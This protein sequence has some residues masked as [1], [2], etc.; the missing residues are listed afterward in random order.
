MTTLFII[1][2]FVDIHDFSPFPKVM[3]SISKE[4]FNLPRFRENWKQVVWFMFCISGLVKELK[5]FLL[6]IDD[7]P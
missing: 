7:L 3:S 2:S 1:F 4:T 5:D 6:S